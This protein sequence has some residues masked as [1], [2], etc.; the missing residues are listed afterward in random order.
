MTTFTS[1]LEIIHE[2]LL[3]TAKHSDILDLKQEIRKKN[4]QT[5]SPNQSPKPETTLRSG[6][7][8]LPMNT[9]NDDTII[10]QTSYQ[11]LPKP[12]NS[13]NKTNLDDKPK[14]YILGDSVTRAIDPSRMSGERL[15]IKV[16]SH[17]G[18]KINYITRNISTSKNKQDLAKYDMFIIHAGINNISNADNC[19]SIIQDYEQLAHE[20]KQINGR[21]KIAISSILK[22]KYDKLSLKTV[23][24][25]NTL[26]QKMCSQNNYIYIDNSLGFTSSDG[27]ANKILYRDEINLTNRGTSVLV[28]SMKASI[29]KCLNILLHTS[30]RDVNFRQAYPGRQ[31][32]SQVDRYRVMIP[33][34]ENQ[35]EAKSVCPGRYFTRCFFRRAALV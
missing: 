20:I 21:T 22:K 17:P 30:Q 5:S 6:Q 12:T 9:L 4:K 24:D 34:T 25:T 29:F 33:E 18:A 19:I 15:Y 16:K 13:N 11:P 23:Q 1:K 2:K 35:Q 10:Q 32:P 3:L 7:N 14:V 27:T 8:T 26:I 28:K 31:I